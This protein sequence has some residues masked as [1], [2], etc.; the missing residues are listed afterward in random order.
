[1][2]DSLLFKASAISAS[3]IESLADLGAAPLGVA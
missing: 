1:M 2:L 3:S